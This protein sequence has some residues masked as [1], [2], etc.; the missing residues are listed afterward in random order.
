M[1]RRGP[2]LLFH[3]RAASG[4]W[5][6]TEPR[7]T[8]PSR[9]CQRALG[10]QVPRHAAVVAGP[11]WARWRVRG[12]AA[13]REAA[14]VAPHARPPLLIVPALRYARALG[15]P[16]L[17]VARL[18]AQVAGLRGALRAR[19]LQVPERPADVAGLAAG[20]AAPAGGLGAGGLEV[21]QDSADV[22]GLVHPGGAS[23]GARAPALAAS[24]RRAA[25]PGEAR[26]VALRLQVP[27]LAADVAPLA[28]IGAVGLQVLEGA[29]QVALLRARAAL[30]KC[31]RPPQL[32]QFLSYGV[33]VLVGRATVVVR[34]GAGGM[35]AAF[36]AV[37]ASGVAARCGVDWSLRCG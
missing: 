36:G 9:G 30:A 33:D 4:H 19:G 32:L 24:R 12:H 18:P 10:L 7:P 2:G 22:A 34:V 31:P 28:R 23:S 25:N 21:A 5:A 37:A 6:S 16:R 3:H 26:A 15:A 29:A 17:E 14:P 1:P 35:A 27:H 8:L 13:V 11:A 20:C